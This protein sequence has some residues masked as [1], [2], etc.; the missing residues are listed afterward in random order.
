[1]RRDIVPSISS[2][3]V[4][5]HGGRRG[6]TRVRARPAAPSDQYNLRSPASPHPAGLAAPAGYGCVRAAT[7]LIDHRDEHCLAGPSERGLRAQTYTRLTRQSERTQAVEMQINKLRRAL[8]GTSRLGHKGD[9]S[10]RRVGH[11]CSSPERCEQ[12]CNQQCTR[13]R[14]SAACAK[15]SHR[16]SIATQGDNGEWSPTASGD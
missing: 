12:C 14:G 3:T 15:P 5:R 10:Q 16:G 13:R 1:M 7:L 6:Q 11:S 8:R 4:C 2:R 9:Q